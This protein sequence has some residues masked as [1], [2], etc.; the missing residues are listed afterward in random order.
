QNWV[1][2][3]STTSVV[4]PRSAHSASIP[5]NSPAVVTS[6]S[7]GAVTTG[8]PP[9][10]KKE[11]PVSG[12][13]ATSSQIPAQVVPGGRAA[14]TGEGAVDGQP[15]TPDGWLVNRAVMVLPAVGTV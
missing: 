11:H 6:I 7:A 14:C 15:G 8:T 4:C 9:T 13:Y 12:N 1:P 5:R 3:M 10:A 2:V